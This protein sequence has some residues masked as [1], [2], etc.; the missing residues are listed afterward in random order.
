VTIQPDF[1][2]DIPDA[3]P[4]KIFLPL[5]DSDKRHREQCIFQKTTPPRFNLLF[6]SGTL[7][8][9]AIDTKQPCVINLDM[10][11]RSVSLEAMIQNIVN[12]QVLEM[13]ARKT[14]SHEQMREYFRID[15]ILPIVISSRIPEGID[16]PEKYWQLAGTTIDMSG[17]G[18]LAI[19]NA[20][21]PADKLVKLQFSLPDEQPNP[22]T[23]LASPVRIT[24]VEKNRYVVAYY[25]EEINDDDRDRI[26]G[27]CLITQR[28]QL[29]LK[30]QIVKG[31]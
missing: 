6:K 29:R 13:I 19:F 24:E 15:Y 3:K 26:I 28:R 11:G 8:I 25:F 27:Q 31:S 21:P 23:L 1:L 18:L 7:P 30:V 17:C 16:V 9:Q 5:Q 14:V 10:A 22:I 20:K 4:V 12:G 2:Q